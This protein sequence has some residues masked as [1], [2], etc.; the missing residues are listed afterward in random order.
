MCPKGIS[1]RRCSCLAVLLHG[2]CVLVDVVAGTSWLF[3][4]TVI[5]NQKVLVSFVMSS[6]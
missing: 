5:G 6:D 2:R 4:E 1:S 3:A